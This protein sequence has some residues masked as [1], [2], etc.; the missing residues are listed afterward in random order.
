M[1]YLIRTT[2]RNI[3]VDAGCVTMPGFV[4]EDFIGPV[5]ALE[6]MGVSTDKISR[7]TYLSGAKSGDYAYETLDFSRIVT[8]KLS[9]T[10]IWQVA[11][12]NI[13]GLIAHESA[14]NGGVTMDV[15]DLG[16][17]PEDW[18]TLDYRTMK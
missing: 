6:R 10:N 2:D 3:L 7:I 9:P 11:R 8:G 5:V 18:E 1:I 14:M 12:Y 17:P 13:P 4:M 16:N 15:P